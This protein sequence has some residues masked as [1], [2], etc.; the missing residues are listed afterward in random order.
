MP[1]QANSSRHVKVIVLRPGPPDAT[2]LFALASSATISTA[3]ST[4]T[5]AATAATTTTAA[6]MVTTSTVIVA[7]ATAVAAARRG[8]TG[9]K[10]L[11][12]LDGGDIWID[13]RED[14]VWMTGPTMHVFSGTFTAEFLESLG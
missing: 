7:T 6:T 5:T 12:T 4:A 3:A 8:V 11:I 10:V 13:W 2:S 9:R 1:S 14:G